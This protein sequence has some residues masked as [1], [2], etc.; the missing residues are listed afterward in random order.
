L[1]A[2]NWIANEV[3]LHIIAPTF[4]PVTVAGAGVS[5]VELSSRFLEKLADT[6]IYLNQRTAAAFPQWKNATV[7]V[8]CNSM[9][10]PLQKASAMLKLQLAGFPGYPRSGLC[11]FPFGPMLPLSFRGHGV[12][13]IHDTLDLDLP[14]L[15]SP[16]ERIFRNVIMPATARH[17]SIVTIS[18][19]SRDRLRHH[20]GVEAAV[21]PLAVQ[22]LPLPSKAKVPASPYVF[23][24]ANGYAHKNH[25]FLLDLW[26]SRPELKPLSLVF[27]LG[28]GA[29]SLAP[30]L[31]RARKSGID[32][33][34]TGR[35]SREE[36]AGLYENAVC[37]VL[38]TL[39]EGFGLPMQEALLCNCPV[40]ANASCLALLETVSA[41]YP[42]F[43]PLEPE[44]WTNAILAMP[45]VSRENL[46][47]Y[48]KSRTWDDCA[49]EYVDFFVSV[50]SQ[51]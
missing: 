10:S 15:L 32:I 14:K 11:W 22:S 26:K 5:L 37:T 31:R 42:H 7:V 36:L 27:T 41:D 39:Y 48:V 50:A 13:T 34:V 25:R 47:A 23:F 46:R 18:T 45:S 51:P 9:S 1:V 38:P 17:T 20:Y 19:F 4:D 28:S 24:P 43:L 21:I 12:S 35:V 16:V 44:H 3:V 40:V 6:R 8:Q 30:A 2:R 49:R 33:I 29:Q